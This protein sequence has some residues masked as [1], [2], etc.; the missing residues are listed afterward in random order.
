MV[1]LGRGD[2]RMWDNSIQTSYRHV[3][4]HGLQI[5]ANYTFSKQIS[6][7]GW[8]NTYAGVPQRSL[9]TFDRP[10]VFKFSSHYELPFGKGRKF[11][12]SAGRALNAVIGGWDLNASTTPVRAN[13]RICRRTPSCSRNRQ[14]R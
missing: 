1:Q 13:R 14:S 12:P 6:Q 4:R 11:A 7:E 10:H 3:F 2:G 9:T 8:M 5:N